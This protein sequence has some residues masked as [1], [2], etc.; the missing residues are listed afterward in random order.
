[1]LERILGPAKERNGTWRMK[2]NGKL[3]N[4]IKKNFITNYI[5]AQ[6]L[7]WFGHVYRMINDMTI[8]KLFEWKQIYTRLAGR[9]ETGWENDTK[10]ELRVMK[11][12]NWTKSIQNRVKWKE[13]VEKAKFSN[14]G[15]VVSEEKE[16]F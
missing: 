6:R 14:S 2:I 10:E 1:M 8:K 7:S 16:D 5:K 11:V 13:V 15:V 12:N 9:Q 3:N 4:L